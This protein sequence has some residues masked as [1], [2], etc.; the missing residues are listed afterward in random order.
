MDKEIGSLEP[1]KLAD[2]IVLRKNPLEDIRNSEAIDLVVANGRVYDAATMNEVGNHPR[3]RGR[4]YWE[5]AKGSDAFPWHE[6]AHGFM[7]G[8][9]GCLGH[10][11]H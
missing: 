2:F 4:F 5:R 6:A 1:G 10:E 8:S 9:C 11:V 3:E 7:G